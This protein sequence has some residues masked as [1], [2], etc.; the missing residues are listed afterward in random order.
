MDSLEKLWKGRVSAAVEERFAALRAALDSQ[1]PAP[2][3]GVK[4]AEDKPREPGIRQ[5]S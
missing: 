1:G 4:E 2:I 5:Q 3:V